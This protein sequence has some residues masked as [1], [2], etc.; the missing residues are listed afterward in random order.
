MIIA[1]PHLDENKLTHS[2]DGPH[3]FPIHDKTFDKIWKNS[4][5]PSPHQ[6]YFT[7]TQRKFPERINEEAEFVAMIPCQHQDNSSMIGKGK[8]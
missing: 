1:K 4:S 2:P 7:L 6:N 8:T 3:L 5:Q